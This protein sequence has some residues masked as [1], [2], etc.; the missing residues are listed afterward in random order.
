MP[1][2]MPVVMHVEFEVPD[3]FGG[4][5]ERGLTA[6]GIIRAIPREAAVGKVAAPTP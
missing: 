6:G 5:G 4:P 3:P 1:N 2:P